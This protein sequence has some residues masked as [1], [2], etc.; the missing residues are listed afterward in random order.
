MLLTVILHVQYHMHVHI[1]LLHVQY[2]SKHVKETVGYIT[3]EVREVSWAGHLKGTVSMHMQMLF[4]NR[5]MA[6]E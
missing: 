5:G 3:L 2:Q 6:K 1:V 4:K